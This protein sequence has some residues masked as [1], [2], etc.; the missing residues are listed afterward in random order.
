MGVRVAS[1]TAADESADNREAELRRAAKLATER[2]LLV[3][4]LDQFECKIKTFAGTDTATAVLL[5]PAREALRVRLHASTA[6]LTAYGFSPEEKTQQKQDQAFTPPTA[7]PQT[8]FVPDPGTDYLLLE[9]ESD[10]DESDLALAVRLPP[11]ELEFGLPEPRFESGGYVSGQTNDDEDDACEELGNVKVRADVSDPTLCKANYVI[12][13]DGSP[14]GSRTK[15]G[16][17]LPG[18]GRA[19][20]CVNNIVL[21]GRK[22]GREELEELGCAYPVDWRATRP[23]SLLRRG[24]RIS[25]EPEDGSD[26]EHNARKHRNRARESNRTRMRAN[27][28]TTKNTDDEDECILF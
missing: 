6:E 19:K 9:S 15:I 14:E 2:A 12:D 18:D 7:R 1:A 10:T 11:E 22:N 25:D 3:A 21:A 28:S 20:Q 5:V 4:A 27:E 17:K 8:L 24:S 26:L 16:M 13:L 23:I